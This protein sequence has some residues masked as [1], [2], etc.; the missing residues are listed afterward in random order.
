M[1]VFLQGEDIVPRLRGFHVAPGW[2]G[3]CN[4]IAIS[5]SSDRVR[6]LFCEHEW[7][8]QPRSCREQIIGEYRVPVI[9]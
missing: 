5:S 4:V 2:E 6:T 7:H 9:T 8:V 3:A 1:A